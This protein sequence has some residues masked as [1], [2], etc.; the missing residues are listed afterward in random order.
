[1]A[2]VILAL[3][4]RTLR[5][6]CAEALRHAGHA[7]VEITRPLALLD[8]ETRLRA[9]AVLVD[10][11]ALGRDALRAGAIDFA[12][13]LI[14]VGIAGRAFASSLTLPLEA[15]Q[16]VDAVRSLAVAPAEASML[17]LEAG[18]RVARANGREVALT[19][20]EAQLLD[21]LLS[22]RGGVV[23]L[24]EAMES[25][26]GAGDWTRNLSLLRA[27]MRNLRL[28]LAQVGLANAVRSRR[29]RGYALAL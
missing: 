24:D 12:G 1:M 23:T 18:R 2:T 26:W 10:A 7:V 20:T 13:R 17:T 27:H 28:K 22:R 19:R 6:F 8:L 9:D 4:D 14:G 29:G 21:A 11:S 3:G 16:L 5:E 25:L 15:R